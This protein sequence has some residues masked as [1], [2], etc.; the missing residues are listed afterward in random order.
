MKIGGTY[1]YLRLASPSWQQLY[2]QTT[3]RLPRPRRDRECVSI[4]RPPVALRFW[5]AELTTPA[6]VR[7]SSFDQQALLGPR[8]YVVALDSIIRAYRQDKARSWAPYLYGAR[9]GEWQ[10]ILRLGVSTCALNTPPSSPPAT[11]MGPLVSIG[12]TSAFN[13]SLGVLFVS[14][15]ASSLWVQQVVLRA[16]SDARHWTNDGQIVQYWNGS[17]DPVFSE[18]WRWYPIFKGIRT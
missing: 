9:E 2:A 3:I 6:P 11:A 12:P 4:S 5:S 1:I 14:F 8:D 18:L 7:R 15:V 10:K 17:D 13:N 16:A